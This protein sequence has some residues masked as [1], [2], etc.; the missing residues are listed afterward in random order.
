MVE[1]PPQG[2]SPSNY[3]ISGRYADT[4]RTS[5]Q[6]VDF[7]ARIPFSSTFRLSPRLRYGLR[8][9]K[10]VDGT[11]WDGKEPAKYADSFKVKA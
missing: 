2:T 5:S 11:T 10:L 7:T 4:Q 9:S 3:I 1:K 6:T 8:S